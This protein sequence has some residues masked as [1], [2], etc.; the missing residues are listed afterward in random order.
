MVT[1]Y[2]PSGCERITRT[3]FPNLATTPRANVYQD[4]APK[5]D[6]TQSSDADITEADTTITTVV[7]GTQGGDD[8]KHAIEETTAQGAEEVEGAGRDERGELDPDICGI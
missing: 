1:P 4:V 8:G 7:P 3:L 6:S 5:T 2:S